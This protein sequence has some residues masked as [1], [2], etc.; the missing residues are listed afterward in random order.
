MNKL[1]KLKKELIKYKKTHNS[2]DPELPNFDYEV[3]QHVENLEKQIIDIE[4]NYSFSNFNKF[5]EYLINVGIRSL[6][7][8]YSDEI[9]FSNIEYFKNCYKRN[10]SAYKALLLLPYK[11][12]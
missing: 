12:N 10:L 4:L 3:Y 11:A 5:H 2:Y 1:E 6:E 8:G 7:Y 9:L